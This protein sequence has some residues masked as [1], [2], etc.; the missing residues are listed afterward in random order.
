VVKSIGFGYG[1][2]Q[3]CP[4]ALWVVAEVDAHVV[5]SDEVFQLQLEHPFEGLVVSAKC[6]RG[7]LIVALVKVVSDFLHRDLQH[8]KGQALGHNVNTAGRG[9]LWGR[10]KKGLV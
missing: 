8:V 2:Y 6:S 3:G 1:G 7:R 10:R 5:E 9:R 4:E